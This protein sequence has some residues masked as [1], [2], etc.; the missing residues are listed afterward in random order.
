MRLTFF[1]R[2]REAVGAGEIDC[3]PPATIV[4]S[5]SLREWISVDHPALA[6]ATVRIALDDVL[7]TGPTSIAG[8][9]EVA[10]LPPV[11]GG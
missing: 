4:D 2:L 9:S 10:F 8:V 1:G 11:S 3:L 6:D 5:E 7:I